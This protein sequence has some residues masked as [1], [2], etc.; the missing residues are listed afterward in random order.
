MLSTV[1]SVYDPLGFLAPISLQGKRLL[2][3]LCVRG[4]GWD[5]PI[6]SDMAS[7]WQSWLSDVKQLSELRIRRCVK[8][9]GFSVAKV[10][11]HH[12]CDGSL[13]GFV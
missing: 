1:M 7:Q 3:L 6:S 5:D 8:P 9:P 13:L 4:L 2:Q 11:F 10:E 12:F